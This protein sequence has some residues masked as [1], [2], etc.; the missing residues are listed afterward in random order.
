MI[1]IDDLCKVSDLSQ[2]QL[3]DTIGGAAVAIPCFITYKDK[4][5]SLGTT[6]L[7]RSEHF[8]YDLNNR[9]VKI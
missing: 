2:R 4:P 8:E 1:R 5:L 6:E 3:Q 9:L 7:T